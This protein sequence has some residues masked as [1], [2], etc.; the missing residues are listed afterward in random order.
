[1]TSA[2][3]RCTWSFDPDDTARGSVAKYF[4]NKDADPDQTDRNNKSSFDLALDG[5]YTNLAMLIGGVKIKR[6]LDAMTQDPSRGPAETERI[7]RTIERMK[8]AGIDMQTVLNQDMT[9]GG[10]SLLDLFNQSEQEQ[11]TKTLFQLPLDSTNWVQV[12]RRPN[13]NGLT[14]MQQA[15]INRKFGVV[16][17]F[18][19][20]LDR[21]GDAAQ[22]KGWW[23][24]CFATGSRNRCQHRHHPD[25]PCRGRPSRTDQRRPAAVI[26][27]RA[28]GSTQRRASLSSPHRDQDRT[29]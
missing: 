17:I 6:H 21:L 28:V 19:E 11:I 13:R 23:T 3:R 1:M 2:R 15:A 8:D 25:P 14:G 12:F 5:H 27:E 7:K 26:T 9:E 24:R 20:N 16:R 18:L 4:L 10:G 22:E 29:N